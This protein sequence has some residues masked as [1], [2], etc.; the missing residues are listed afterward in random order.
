LENEW[1]ELK[2]RR[3]QSSV[4]V[5]VPLPRHHKVV[6]MALIEQIQPPRFG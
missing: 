6:C 4:V 3:G 2:I 5:Q 1:V